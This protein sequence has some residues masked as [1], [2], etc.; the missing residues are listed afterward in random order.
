MNIKQL[1]ATSP[2]PSLE[3]EILLASILGRDRSFLNAFAQTELTAEQL[4]KAENYFTRRR[5]KEPIPYILGYKEFYGRNFFVNKDVLI[6]RPETE[7]LVKTVVD[8]AK[9]KKVIIADIGTGSGCIAITLALELPQVTVIASDIDEKTLRVAEK[10]A[11]LHNVTEKIAFIKSDLMEKIDSKVDLIITNLPYIPN[12]NWEN[13]P[14]TIKDYEPKI[15]L[16]SGKSKLSFYHKL[17]VQA[18]ERKIKNIFYEID[19]EIIHQ[20]L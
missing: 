18:K 2:A 13:L 6:P 10:N 12:K 11:R 19:G 3:S 4:K 8:F 5:H 7:E 15:A 9:N 16:N 17:F 1:L 20:T 14:V